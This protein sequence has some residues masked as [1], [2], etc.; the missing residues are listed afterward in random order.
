MLQ[1]SC[2]KRSHWY[3]FYIFREIDYLKSQLK[4]FNML[5]TKTKITHN[6]S[7]AILNI[8]NFKVDFRVYLNMGRKGLTKELSIT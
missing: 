5:S 2:G 3:L 1:I 8:Q 4:I 7:C 6:H